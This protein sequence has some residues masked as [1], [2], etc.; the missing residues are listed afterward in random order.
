[1]VGFIGFGHVGKALAQTLLSKGELQIAY[2]DPFV[3]RREIPSYSE[4]KVISIGQIVDLLHDCQVIFIT[5]ADDLISDVVN[6]IAQDR[7]VIKEK[8]FIHTSGVHSVAVLEPLAIAGGFTASIHP[9]MVFAGHN[10]AIK[11]LQTAY[12]TVEYNVENQQL[13]GILNQLGNPLL[14]VNSEDKAL[15]HSGACVLSNY[16]T[17]V[18]AYGLK[19][20]ERATGAEPE[21]VLKAVWPLVMSAFENIKTLG[22]EQAL[23]G[24]MK[25]Q[26]IQTLNKHFERMKKANEGPFYHQLVTETLSYMKKNGYPHERIEVLNTEVDI[27][28]HFSQLLK[29]KVLD[30]SGKAYAWDNK[31][32]QVLYMNFPEATLIP[33]HSHGAQMGIVLEG[34]ICIT[35]EGQKRYYVKGDVYIIGEGVMHESS[36]EAGYRDLTIFEVLT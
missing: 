19:M 23:S 2:F 25:R 20:M 32:T 11:D 21:D 7:G 29:P 6:L 35:I 13:Q 34:N 27:M 36:I 5:V 26:D 17:V 31:K 28:A 1:M 8:L 15:Y 24:P 12:L 4:E 3:H 22:V 18:M 10:Q 33:E 14:T 16:V 30:M 9:L